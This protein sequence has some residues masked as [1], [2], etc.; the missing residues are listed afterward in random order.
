MPKAGHDYETARLLRAKGLNYKDIAAQTG[1]SEVALSRYAQ[2]HEWDKKHDKLV[3]SVSVNVAARHVNQVTRLCQDK[4]DELRS[5]DFNAAMRKLDAEA[6]VRCVNALDVII[7]RALRMDEVT[8]NGRAALAIQ[9]NVNGHPANADS[10]IQDAEL[11]ADADSSVA[12][13]G[14]PRG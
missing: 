13:T 1:I 14:S 12:D 6:F 3:A 7:R 11:I 4:L 9:V 10:S 2:R 5:Y 8:S